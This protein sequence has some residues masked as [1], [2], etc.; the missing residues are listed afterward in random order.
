[1]R[2]RLR[3]RPVEQFDREHRAKSIIAV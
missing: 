1:L 2:F 3:F